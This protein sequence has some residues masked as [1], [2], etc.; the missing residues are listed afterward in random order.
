VIK[1]VG[2]A[3]KTAGAAHYRDSLPLTDRGTIGVR[4]LGRIELY[5][6][7]DEKIKAPIAVV[8]EPG[9][10]RAPSDLFVVDTAF[11]VTSVNDPSP[12]LWNKM[13]CPRSSRTDSSH[14]SLS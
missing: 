3:G 14:P 10:A 13:L 1:D 6:V 7:T 8:V 12:L 5:V 4:R 9:A 2:V 11:R